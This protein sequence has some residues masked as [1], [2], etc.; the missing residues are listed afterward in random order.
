MYGSKPNSKISIYV[1]VVSIKTISNKTSQSRQPILAK[2]TLITLRPITGMT[3]PIIILKGRPFSSQVLS[4]MDMSNSTIK[5]LTSLPPITINLWDL[6]L[7]WANTG[8]ERVFYSTNCFSWRIMDSK[9]NNTPMHAHKEYGC[10]R[11]RFSI[12][13]LA[14]TCSLWVIFTLLQTPK[15]LPACKK[16][17]KMTSVYSLWPLFSLH[18]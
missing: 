7:Q 18:T 4:L 8:L 13:S 9:W 15:D 12:N 2:V 16:A 10:G 1:Q 11:I 3:H 6:Q 17:S 5:L 14:I